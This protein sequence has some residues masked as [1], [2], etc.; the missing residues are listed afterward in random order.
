MPNPFGWETTNPEST[1]LLEDGEIH[2]F[3]T[4]LTPN[5][6]W[7]DAAFSILDGIERER[8]SRFRFDVDRYRFQKTRAALRIFLARYLSIQPAEITF[9]EGPH[10]KPFL[11][12][13][14]SDLQFNVSH[15][16]GAA[17]LAFTRSI[18]LGVDIE[19]GRRKVDIEG[20]GRRVFTPTERAGFSDLGKISGLRQFFRLWTAKEAYLKAVGSGLSCDP[21][22]IEAELDSGRFKPAAEQ[23][24]ELPYSL[25]ELAT[26]N[27]FIVSLAYQSCPRPK[28]R[29]AEFE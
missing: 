13:P 4:R 19:H 8:A 10:G 11:R 25:I 22:T 21:S 1:P 3:A 20:V 18:E 16:R 26:K 2:I 23:E 15:T 24:R 7:D 29:L 12:S 14:K 5:S 28:L 27:E 6:R 9:R 17:V